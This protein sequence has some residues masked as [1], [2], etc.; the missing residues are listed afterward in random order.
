MRGW[1]KKF[2]LGHRQSPDD[3]VKQVG[4]KASFKCGEGR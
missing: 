4:F 3:K 2:Y 1:L